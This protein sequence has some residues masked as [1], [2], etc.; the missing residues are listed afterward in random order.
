MSRSRWRT[1]PAGWT[2]RA[3]RLHNLKGSA[4]TL[5][6]K[7]VERL[8]AQA[9][10]ACRAGDATRAGNLVA[11]LAAQLQALSR[12]ADEFIVEHERDPASAAVPL[13]GDL[14][15]RDLA[16]L[17]D[18]L[19]SSDL[20]ALQRF[21]EWAPELRRQLGREAYAALREQMDNLQ[22]AEVAAALTA[23]LLLQPAAGAG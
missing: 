18:Q 15:P 22:F 3:G 13:D 5:G 11:L 8:A 20:S 4:G 23:Q 6:A 14:D 17:I 12:H 10:Q 19:R 21:A 9:E 2:A 7:S 16:P 1:S